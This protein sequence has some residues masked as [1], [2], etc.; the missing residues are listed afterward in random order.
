MNA[1][2]LT[3]CLSVAVALGLGCD[4]TKSASSGN[5]NNAAN[6]AKSASAEHAESS[7][8][9]K[10]DVESHD[11]QDH[12]SP[13]DPHADAP[14][15]DVVGNGVPSLDEN[16]LV[17]LSKLHI[18]RRPS[19]IKPTNRRDATGDMIYAT[20]RVQMDILL[21]DRKALLDAGH[22]V[23]D[24]EVRR[25]EDS[26]RKAIALLTENGEAIEPIDP[27]IEGLVLPRTDANASG[28]T[29]TDYVP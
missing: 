4:A 24:P 7:D 15:G 5:S 27:P 26:I 13:D 3:A 28:T 20:V 1:L 14:H 9:P 17:D 18:E 2:T 16:G 21:A 11:S 25:K 19:G 8:A 29:D 23:T 22:D 10:S 6:S 12:A